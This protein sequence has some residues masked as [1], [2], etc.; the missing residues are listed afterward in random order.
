MIETDDDAH[1]KVRFVNPGNRDWSTALIEATWSWT[2]L[3]PQGSDVRGYLEV[4]GSL[5][6]V[7]GIV[8][9]HDQDFLRVRSRAFGERLI[10]VGAALSDSDVFKLE[11]DNFVKCIRVAV[12]SILNAEVGAGV[13]GILNAAQLSELRGRVSVTPKDVAEFSE[14]LAADAPDAWQAGDRIISALYAPFR[15]S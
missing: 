6:T 9:E 10:P 7:T 1:F 11:I 12:P 8:D 15:L 13:T 5:G 3:G 2:E 14:Q 4:E